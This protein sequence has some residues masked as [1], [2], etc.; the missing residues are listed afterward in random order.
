MVP[1]SPSATDPHFYIRSIG[2]FSE[3]YRWGLL[4]GW[5][6]LRASLMKQEKQGQALALEPQQSQQEQEH[7]TNISFY[8]AL[9]VDLEESLFRNVLTFLIPSREKKRSRSK[10]HKDQKRKAGVSSA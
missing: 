2:C 9:F 10:K 8:H 3:S 4:R 5:I 7:P 6:L 1:S